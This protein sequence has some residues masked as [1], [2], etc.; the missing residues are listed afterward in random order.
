VRPFHI[1]GR[2]K[3]NFK[4]IGYSS[5]QYIDF[6]REML[7]Y[8]LKKP[9]LEVGTAHLVKKAIFGQHPLFLDLQSPC[10]AAINQ[11]A[12]D[13][14]G[15][16]F[17]CDEGRMVGGDMFRIGHA[18]QSY[19]DVMCAQNIKGIVKCSVNDLLGCKRCAFKPYCGVCPVLSYL[20]YG[21]PVP[22]TGTFECR[23]LRSQFRFIFEAFFTQKSYRDMFTRWAQTKDL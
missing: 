23:V 2:G 14:N 1:M 7:V 5:E 4:N 18:S 6:W 11:L 8:L 22:R 16:I 15:D 13:F 20:E 3:N 12:Y 17:T 21:S 10:G 19:K 9:I